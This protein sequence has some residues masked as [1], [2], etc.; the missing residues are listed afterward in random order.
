MVDEGAGSSR[1]EVQQLQKEVD[2]VE[3]TRRDVT[4]TIA[5]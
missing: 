2:G 3:V 1:A 4:A 5:R